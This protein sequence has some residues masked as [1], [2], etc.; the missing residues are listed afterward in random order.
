MIKSLIKS[1]IGQKNT[2]FIKRVKY[3][4][5]NSRAVWRNSAS[6]FS[7]NSEQDLLSL[8]MSVHTIEKCM[9]VRNSEALNA[10]NYNSMIDN[11][12]NCIKSG[13]PTDSFEISGS[14]AVIRAALN[15]QTGH[16]EA[17]C[18]FQD[19]IAKYDIPENFSGGCEKLSRSEIF[20]HNDFDWGEFVRTRHSIR[21]FK[22]TIISREKIYDI[23]RDTE[24]CPS[25]CNRQPCKVYFSENPATIAKIIKCV[26]D[27][28]VAKGVHDC[29]IVT[30]D[31]N[32]LFNMEFN[33]QEFVNTG[34]FLG[35]L[36]LSIHSHGLGSC[37][38]QFLQVD[39]RQD[40]IRKLFGISSSEVVVAFVGF[41]EL[42]DEN[43]IA[44]AAR[45][46]VESVA[47]NLE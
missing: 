10:L 27:Q 35:Y 32:L 40:R 38:F 26:P 3:L 2:I 36:V 28:F 29:F 21:S 24:Y 46:S 25:A 4:V 18:K 44:C 17:K 14:A 39:S 19:V 8:L 37:L 7:Q 33:D 47:V 23:I 11:L 43:Y 45:K 41:G 13:I 34:I 31:R 6:L 16:D 20:A 22:D 1:I 5:R 15:S 12:E 9:C 30:C 42:D